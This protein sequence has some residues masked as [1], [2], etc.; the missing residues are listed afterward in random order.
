MRPRRA[1]QDQYLL[2]QGQVSPERTRESQ[3][4]RRRHRVCCTGYFARVYRDLPKGA[5]NVVGI[6]AVV[7]NAVD[8]L[9]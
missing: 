4:E 7:E 5:E 8:D 9:A 3:V 2:N 1:S 6:A